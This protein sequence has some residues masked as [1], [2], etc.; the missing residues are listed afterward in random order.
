M[1]SQMSERTIFVV[2]DD[3]SVRESLRALLE[4]AD[5]KVIDFASAVEFLNSA[6]ER[7]GSCIIADVRMPGMNG[8]EMQEEL[9]K[10]GSKL[11]VIIIT[12]HA[13]V[14]MAVQAM[15][16]GAIDF[17][18]KPFDDETLLGCVNRALEAMEKKRDL[19]REAQDASQ[20]ISR[21]T[22]RELEV[23]EQLVAGRS[24]KLVARELSISPRT[25]EIH[26]ARIMDKLKARGL[27]DLVRTAIAAS[28]RMPTD[29]GSPTAQG[30]AAH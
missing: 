3:V 22:P 5:L 19:M 7:R 24:N 20:Q 1:E 27:S 21:L 13:D 18:E 16:A 15:K 6:D 23:L 8:L 17:L 30:H 2:E 28:I 10:R 4:S 29:L 9:V 26:R 11:P 14:A 25:V 12:G